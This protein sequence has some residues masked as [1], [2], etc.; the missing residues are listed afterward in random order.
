MGRWHTS[1][2][3]VKPVVSTAEG[4]VFICGLVT[5]MKRNSFFEGAL[6]HASAAGAVATFEFGAQPS[7]V[8]FEEILKFISNNIDK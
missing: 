6:I 8:T 2:F 7:L 3:K 4:D 5:S 1:T